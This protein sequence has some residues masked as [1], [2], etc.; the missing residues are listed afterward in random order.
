MLATLL[1]SA[2]PSVV[3]ERR[4]GDWRASPLADPVP[5]EG[6]ARLNGIGAGAN[7]IVVSLESTAAQYLGIYGAAPDPTPNLSALVRNAVVFDAAYAL[8]PESIKGLF[9]VSRVR[10]T[11]RRLRAPAVPLVCVCAEGSRLPH[12]AL[13]LGTLRLPRHERDH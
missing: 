9:F 8:Y 10:H 13:S 7:I 5:A 6:L 12:G 1:A 4:D 11:S 2:L 3:A